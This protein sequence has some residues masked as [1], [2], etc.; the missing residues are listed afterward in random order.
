VCGDGK[1]EALEQCDG[2]NLNGL[3]CGDFAFGY[4]LLGSLAY[5]EGSLRCGAECA[6][7]KTGCR[8]PPGCYWVTASGLPQV[9]C[10]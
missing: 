3:G 7:D 6:F 2:A 8:P 9:V 10:Y 5:W 1:V 4:T